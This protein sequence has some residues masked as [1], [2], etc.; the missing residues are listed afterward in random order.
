MEDEVGERTEEREIPTRNEESTEQSRVSHM[1]QTDTSN[2]PSRTEE[3]EVNTSEC[4][5][6]VSSGAV[7]PM[8]IGEEETEINERSDTA[9]LDSGCNMSQT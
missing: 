9:S 2:N 6:E 3:G 4:L 5:D 8:S 1:D 7:S